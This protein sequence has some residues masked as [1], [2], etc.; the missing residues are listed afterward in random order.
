M[1]ST[2]SNVPVA[3]L[4]PARQGVGV[5]VS[6]GQTIKVI[7]TYGKQVVDTWAFNVENA[8]E[9]LSMEHTRASILKLVPCIGDVLV[10]NQRRQMLTVIEDT[11]PG[12]HDMLIAACDVYRYEQLGAIGYHDNCSDNLR[13]ALNA[14]GINIATVP[15]PLNLFMN[16]PFEQNGHLSFKA[17][18][19]MA[20]QYVSFRV[21]MDMIMVF[22]ACPQD[23]VPVNDMTP[24]D[25]HYTIL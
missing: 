23:M 7:N 24:M 15:S 20:G 14:L 2:A 1:A 25:A 9:Y 13:R 4:I 12:V 21:E 6:Q 17:P 16:V 11:T 18:T 10:S 8:A 5:R 3:R 22:S 19:S